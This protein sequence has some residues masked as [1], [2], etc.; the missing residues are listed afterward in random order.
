M[1]R[2]CSR[3]FVGLVSIFL[4]AVQPTEAGP[5]AIDGKG[6]TAVLPAGWS[7]RRVDRITTELW[8]ADKTAL[9]GIHVTKSAFKSS[10]E[11]AAYLSNFTKRELAKQGLS[12][13]R[14]SY[15]KAKT[16]SG[17]QGYEEL[18]DL[19]T[20]G[21]SKRLYFVVGKKAYALDCETGTSF[22][23]MHQPAFNQVLQ[24][25]DIK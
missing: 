9:C 18:V 12:Q 14:L 25:F 5:R 21:R 1:K 16:K 4:L 8:S 22:W 6:W 15:R 13:V 3:A 11:L 24:S 20:G 7:M 19:R 2:I 10:S 23:K 17:A